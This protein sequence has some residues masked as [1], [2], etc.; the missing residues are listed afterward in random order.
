MRDLKIF[1]LTTE[2]GVIRAGTGRARKHR[3]IEP[4]SYTWCKARDYSP[5]VGSVDEAPSE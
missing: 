2:V 3:Y 1:N 5:T 4:I